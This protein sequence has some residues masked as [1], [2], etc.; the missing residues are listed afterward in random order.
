MEVD[1][2]QDSRTERS[3]EYFSKSYFTARALKVA[4]PRPWEV[5]HE[6]ALL[7]RYTL[8]PMNGHKKHFEHVRIKYSYAFNCR[9]P[10]RLHIRLA[11]C[12]RD[13]MS[14]RTTLR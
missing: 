3:A 8:Q 1:K 13:V 11:S 7:F 12:K 2:P 6:L 14:S 10:L 9:Y 5:I 4:L